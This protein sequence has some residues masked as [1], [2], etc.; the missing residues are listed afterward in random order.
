MEQ[1]IESIKNMPTWLIIF[2]III[3]VYF[4]GY[5]FYVK[6]SRGDKAAFLQQNP[7]A[8]SVYMYVGQQLLKTVE[9]S[10]EKVD[11]EYHKNF[12]NEGTRIV[13]M[14]LPGEHTLDVSAST[15]RPGVTHK[16]VTE[17]FGP[18]KIK[19]NIEANKS[20]I[21]GFDTKENTFTFTEK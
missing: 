10:I 14:I 5:L 13:Y 7:T 8:A 1:F 2:P 19:V 15:T 12:F 6:K 9:V 21:V 18:Q 20:Y 16:T 3:V 17:I 11:G 4:I